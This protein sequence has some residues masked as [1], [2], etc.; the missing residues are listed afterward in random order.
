MRGRLDFTIAALDD[1]WDVVRLLR[2]TIATPVTSFVSVI[3]KDLLHVR[4]RFARRLR[5][6]CVNSS[7]VHALST[8]YYSGG[9]YASH[10][11]CSIIIH[12]RVFT[13]TVP[14]RSRTLAGQGVRPET[15]L[16]F[17]FM[18]ALPP[19]DYRETLLNLLYS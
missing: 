2:Q 13:V 3:E 10:I 4:S 16:L 15:E 17:A 12:K 1:D 19:A 11:T 9:Y 18:Y 8:G 14:C 6:S 5:V 7:R